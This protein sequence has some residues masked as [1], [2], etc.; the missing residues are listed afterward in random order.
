MKV[1]WIPQVDDFLYE[2]VVEQWISVE[3][4][5]NYQTLFNDLDKWIYLDLLNFNSFTE[6]NAKSYLRSMI[7]ERWVSSHT[8]N[9]HLVQANQF[10][11][12]LIEKWF[13]TDNPFWKIRKRKAEKLLP[14]YLTLDNVKELQKKVNM[15]RRDKTYITQRNKTII[16]FLLFTWLRMSEMLS[17][18][19][20]DISEKGWVI[21]INKWKWDKD[22]IIPYTEKIKAML[23]KLNEYKD[24]EKIKSSYIFSSTTWKKLRH[25]DI[26][27]FFE[28]IN[29]SLSFHLTPHR[30]RHTYATELVRQ[31]IN[32][33]SIKTLLWHSKVETT[34]IYLWCDINKTTQD[35][36]NKNLYS[37]NI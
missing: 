34:Q 17:L 32:L 33:Y 23:E 37:I 16:Y 19:I 13:I 30:L 15:I 36:N 31:N 3:T 5:K 27:R 9:R 28:K 29:K 26:Y 2:K 7:V 4:L 1:Y 24:L 6:I 11:K 22:R 20:D 12:Y 35:I 8:Y 21:K 14:K 18:K 25:K 10:C